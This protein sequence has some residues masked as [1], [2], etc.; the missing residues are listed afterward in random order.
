M[1][2]SE[3]SDNVSHMVNM[4]GLR[5]GHQLGTPAVTSQRR[6]ALFLVR[7]CSALGVVAAI[8]FVLHR[9]ITV[10]ATT[11]GFLFLVAVLL[12]AT[13]AGLW[14]AVIASVA[15]MFAF[16]LFFLP[17]IGTLTI[18]DPQNWVALFA[19]LATSLTASHLSARA[20]RRALEAEAGRAEMERLYSFSRALLL[21]DPTQPMGTETVRQIATTWE[22]PSVALYLQATSE[23][24]SIGLQESEVEARLHEC[25]LRSVVFRDEARNLIVA[26][27]R[28]GGA[29][30]GSLAIGGETFSDAALHSLLNLVAINLERAT[31]QEAL[32][33]AAVAKQSQE[34]K[35]TLLDVVAHEFKTPLTSIKAV[36]SDLLSASGEVDAHQHELIS[37]VDESADRLSSL[38]SDAIQ[39]ARIEGGTFRLNLGD[40]PPSSLVNR[41][42]RQMKSFI[43]DRAITCSV[44]ENLPAV[45]VDAE[46]IQIVIAHLLDNAFKYSPPRSPVAI[47][48]HVDGDRVIID[49]ADQGH[50][51]TK[52]E[53]EQVFRKFYRGKSDQHLRGTGMGLAIAREI[54]HA[55]GEEIWVSSELGRGTTFSFSLPI[56]KQGAPE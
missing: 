23:V 24:Y 19:F 2:A 25:V 20:K 5:E 35:S 36:T 39:L 14:E 4:P 53:Q 49:V 44:P 43:E 50:G 55:H 40:H 28:L 47:A 31:S 30:I 33:Q 7:I 48:A 12:V 18:A 46:L 54:M 16:N 34:L 52:E 9:V 17:P 27:I 21:N 26:P 41:A 42:V 37:I 15:A 10:N 38:V 11:A 6:P 29:P 8:T 22:C 51:I 45:R 3:R 56:T 13:K 32:N 1:L